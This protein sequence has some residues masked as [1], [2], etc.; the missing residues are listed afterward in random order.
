MN[1]R[2][3]LTH[4]CAICLCSFL[5]GFVAQVTVNSSSVHAAAPSAD[6]RATQ[7]FV[8]AQARKRMELGISNDQPVQNF[9]GDDG[10]VRLRIGTYPGSTERGQPMTAFWD[11]NGNLKMLFRV[12]GPNQSP[13]IVMKDN[14]HHDRIVMGLALSDGKQEPFL[15]TFDS[16]GNKKMVFGD[17]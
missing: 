16:E 14:Q 13:V 12:A 9:Y 3:F 8:D 1:K 11:T 4:F 15:A 7:T 5:G 6:E 17:Y 10:Q 2:T